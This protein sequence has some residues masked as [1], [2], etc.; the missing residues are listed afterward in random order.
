MSE[1]DTASV[2]WTVASG[3]YSSRFSGVAVGAVAVAARKLA[4]KIDAIR[5]H[6]GDADLRCAGSQAWRTGTPRGSP[7]VRSPG[8]RVGVLGAAEPRSSGHR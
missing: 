7:P 5:A 2:P 3:N 6:V 8:L 4:A 1:V